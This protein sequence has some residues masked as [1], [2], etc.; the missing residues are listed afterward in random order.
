MEYSEWSI[1]TLTNL[2]PASIG[3]N[4]SSLFSSPL[5]FFIICILLLDVCVF[6]LTYP[7]D[8]SPLLGDLYL[9][10]R[11]VSLLL[12][13]N[14]GS[15]NIIEDVRVCATT[16]IVVHL[17]ACHYISYL[18]HQIS[19]KTRF[20]GNRISESQQYTQVAQMQA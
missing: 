12:L 1:F 19:S 6:P 8:L 13:L 14:Q 3:A 7:I 4:P 9:S 15:S 17:Y 2:F 20:L 11:H 16:F 5:G 10:S 18:N